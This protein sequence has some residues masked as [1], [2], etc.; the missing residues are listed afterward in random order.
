[1]ADL[2]DRAHRVAQVDG[3][4]GEQAA[5]VSGH[6]AG[7]LV[8]ADEVTGRSVPGCDEGT[9]DPRLV[10]GGDQVVSRGRQPILPRPP[11][12]GIEP[13]LGQE[14]GRRH[15]GPSVDRGRFRAILHM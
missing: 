11:E 12:E 9:L 6:G 2:A 8:V 10:H 14:A 7:D 15:L 5:W 13:G 4:D 3:H 1:V